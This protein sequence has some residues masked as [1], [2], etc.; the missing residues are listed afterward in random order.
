MR[1][2][3]IWLMLCLLPLRLWAGDAMAVQ[4]TPAAA[5]QGHQGLTGAPV[6]AQQAHPCHGAEADAGTVGTTPWAA[7]SGA[8]TETA[9][10]HASG[11]VNTDAAGN[12]HGAGCGDC[13]VCHGPL[14]G[15]TVSVWAAKMLPA[16]VP[17]TMGWPALSATALP[18]LKPPRA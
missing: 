13:S 16:A 7:V 8:A 9:T 3:L 17:Q 18:H 14:A 12:E 11:H 5:H 10:A 1:R 15:L 2:A 4:H 6:M